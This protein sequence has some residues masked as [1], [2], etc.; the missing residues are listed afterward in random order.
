MGLGS[1]ILDDEDTHTECRSCG[2]NLS[3]DVEECPVCGSG[4]AEYDLD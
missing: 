4:V 3:G 2:Q 1:D